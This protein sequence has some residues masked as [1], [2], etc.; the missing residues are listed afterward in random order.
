[1]AAKLQDIGAKSAEC[2]ARMF[3]FQRVNRSGE[4]CPGHL[5]ELYMTRRHAQELKR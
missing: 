2:L 3:L 1:M 5:G 4:V